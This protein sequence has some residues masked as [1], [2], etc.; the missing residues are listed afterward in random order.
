QVRVGTSSAGVVAGSGAVAAAT[1][2]HAV[3]AQ[4]HPGAGLAHHP[5]TV[6][7]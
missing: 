7:Y 5:V 4:H 2:S 3:S 6:N 1:F